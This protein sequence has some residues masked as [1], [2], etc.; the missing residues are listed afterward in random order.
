MFK[1]LTVLLFALSQALPQNIPIQVNG[2]EVAQVI[3]G[4]ITIEDGSGNQNQNNNTGSNNGGNGQ[5]TQVAQSLVNPTRTL[6]QDIENLAN[7]VQNI[8]PKTA[9]DTAKLN[10]ILA[11]LASIDTRFDDLTS[12]LLSA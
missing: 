11:Q 6:Q 4:V 3:N 8:K 2:K 10:S 1:I 9:A 12:D 5:N 7:D